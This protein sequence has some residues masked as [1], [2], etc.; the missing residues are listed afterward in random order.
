MS[1]ATGPT[2][3]RLRA[4]RRSEGG[5]A[6]T[7]DATVATRVARWRSWLHATAIAR[8]ALMGAGAG[9]GAWA[10]VRA[11]VPSPAAASG[12]LGGAL[13]GVPGS[14]LVGVLAGVLVAAVTWWRS[15]T[16]ALSPLRAALW[17]E[18]REPALRYAL[19]TAVDPA[20]PEGARAALQPSVSAVAWEGAARRALA[21]ALRLP[22][23]VAAVGAG[24]ALLVP[25]GGEVAAWRAART[26]A[27]PAEA[28]A[29]SLGETMV[30]VEPPR[31]TGRAAQRLRAPALVRAY[32]GSRVTLS[33]AGDSAALRIALDSQPLRIAAGRDRWEAT[34]AAPAARALLRLGRGDESRLV[35][36]E[37]LV[38]SAPL[39]TL[40]A[41]ARDT[42]LRAPRG[43]IALAADVTDD[44]GIA[45]GA[46]EYIVSSGQGERFTFKSGTLGT[47]SARGATRGTLAGALSL[48]GL[49][50]AAGDVVHLRAVARDRN[51][52][53]G[54]GV[55]AS[56]TRTIR[57][58][59]ADEYDSLAVE[60]APPAEVDQSLLSQRM[61]INLT[62]ALVKRARTLG[63]P[64]VVSQ[65]RAIGRDQARLRKQ[66]SDIIFARLGDGAEAA[67][68]HF[69]GDGHG[70]AEGDSMGKGPLT[71]E[72]LLKAAERATV[73]QGAP[74]DFEHD[75]TPVVAINR[76]MLEAYNAMWEAGRALDGGEPARALP[77]MYVA[78]AAIQR[79]RAAERLYLR[80]APPRVVVDLARVRLAGT[81]RGVPGARTPR[82]RLDAARAPLVA[83]FGRALD[84]LERN[85]AAGVDSLIVLRLAVADRLPAAA[86]ALE[87][88]IGALRASGDATSLLLRARR[89]LDDAPVARDD[90]PAWGVLP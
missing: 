64:A 5:G 62:E 43:T 68:E 37:P 27:G 17:I 90:I 79:A 88:A 33:G 44:L 2:G 77:P 83:R 46:F 24:V 23:I 15:A 82:A 65:S 3:E 72:Q 84:A 22:A 45:S 12:A 57:I 36:L 13:G 75:E 49:G 76:P 60:Q 53:A 6:T 29:S 1:A 80:G 14:A 10:L 51:D 42:V 69:H 40:R 87:A 35:A 86:G 28:G 26:G 25:A 19:V 31:Y 32:P 9:L 47:L 11:A 8:G 7:D 54:P 78:L 34:F 4:A 30:L 38:D 59:R 21:R 70:H 16:R 48:E 89:A 61:L 73:I 85:P 50:L 67:G 58:A 39:V 56:E 63:R 20:V 66:V 18:E 55:G 74:T 41:P 52:V 81:E 71:P